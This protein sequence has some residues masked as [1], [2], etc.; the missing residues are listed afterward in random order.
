LKFIFG[1]AVVSVANNLPL[2]RTH[3]TGVLP[4]GAAEI[5]SFVGPFFEDWSKLDRKWRAFIRV[6][7]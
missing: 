5:D 6:E 1:D 3:P 7:K 4:G 2:D